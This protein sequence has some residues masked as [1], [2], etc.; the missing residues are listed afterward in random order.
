MTN[1]TFK[2]IEVFN[3]LSKEM[4]LPATAIQF[5]KEKT[6]RG[7]I[8]TNEMFNWFCEHF[9]KETATVLYRELECYASQHIE[10]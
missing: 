2:K 5:Y 4:S 9:G 3:A 7:V 6:P 8:T 10:I 1:G